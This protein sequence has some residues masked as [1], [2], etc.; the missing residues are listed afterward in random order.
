VFFAFVT[1]LVTLSLIGFVVLGSKEINSRFQDFISQRFQENF[2][3]E[4]RIS[5][6]E[7]N[8]LGYFSVQDLRLT[9]GNTD[10]GSFFIADKVTFRYPLVNFLSGNFDVGVKIQM[11][12]PVYFL[13]MPVTYSRKGETEGEDN[14]AIEL[15]A[16]FVERVMPKSEI[17]IVDGRLAWQ[18]PAMVIA[19]VNGKFYT[20]AFDVKLSLNHLKI[21]DSDISSEITLLGT[22]SEGN[23]GDLTLNIDV[24]TQQ[25]VF[26]L[27]PL[28]HETVLTVDWTKDQ[29]NIVDSNILGGI[30]VKGKLGFKGKGEVDIKVKM[31][32]YPLAN[33]EPFLRRSR[34]KAMAGR[35][36]ANLALSG[37]LFEP[38]L[39][40]DVMVSEG[41]TDETT[42]KNVQLTLSGVLPVIRISESRVV[43]ADGTAMN[44]AKDTIHIRDLFSKTTFRRLVRERDQEK[45]V[46]GEW[47]MKRSKGSES[48]FVERG[49]TDDLKLRYKS[50][51]TLESYLQSA[52]V[53]REIGL[54]Y[55]FSEE[56]SLR[57]DIKEN[58]EFVGLQKKT[59][60]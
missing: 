18:N 31:D 22:L 49:M 25:S 51:D 13:D 28:A 24:S 53:Q 17:E 44:F 48:I 32:A 23:S 54:E 8:I 5:E 16:H 1:S 20:E 11:Y 37:R 45:V 33:L 38:T 6:I 55:L 47:V 52:P 3:V 4:V 10:S 2:G 30:H 29:I 40:G 26:N 35:V 46:W 14:K 36:Q 56:N 7:S 9:S 21:G 34:E 42:F 12:K 50:Q 41:Y 60:F 15:F 39:Q 58:E 19:T 43:L 27:V 57:V 59:T